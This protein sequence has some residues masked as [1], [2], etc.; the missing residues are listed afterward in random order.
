MVNLIVLLQNKCYTLKIL[1]KRI[2]GLLF[3]EKFAFEISAFGVFQM[4][5]YSLATVVL[6]ISLLGLCF[7]L[8][9]FSM[10]FDYLFVSFYFLLFPCVVVCC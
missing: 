2:I 5:L 9:S 6:L 7:S 1:L 10:C 8:L 3:E 4:I